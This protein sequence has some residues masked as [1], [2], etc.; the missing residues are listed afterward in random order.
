MITGSNSGIGKVTAL[1]VAKK[2]GTVH[3][4]CRS[5]E[6]A[7]TARQEIVSECGHENVHVHIVDMSKPRDVVKFCKEFVASGKQLD[8]LVNNAG[9][10]LN[11]RQQQEDGLEVN[12]ATNS[13]GTYIITKE[14]IP[15]LEK[16]SKPRVVLVSSGGMYLAKLD[17]DD[18]NLER[19]RNFSG[20]Q[21][22]SQQKRQQ[23]IMA[24]R[25]V[26]EYPNIF[27]AS[28]HPGWAD[29]PA[30]QSSLPTFH[31]MMEN[32]LRTPAEGA[33]TVVWLTLSERA[34]KEGPNGGFFQDRQAV[35][36]HLPLASTASTEEEEQRLMVNLENLRKKFNST[37]Q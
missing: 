27:F 33:D 23:V 5:R 17:P 15:V 18:L 7:E 36:E 28:M 30:V 2:G 1:E 6:R 34:V 9:C 20:S 22:Y 12:F 4:V 32:K 8:V 13:L 31:S 16:S 21:S 35:G 24:R 37:E 25:W 19:M 3:M 26:Q 29:T 11:E 14:L 10:L